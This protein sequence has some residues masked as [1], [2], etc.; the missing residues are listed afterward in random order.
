MGADAAK[1]LMIWREQASFR[2]A[3]EI[4]EELRKESDPAVSAA[5]TELR[6]VGRKEAEKVS[7]GEII[8]HFDPSVIT[9]GPG[10]P[11]DPVANQRLRVEFDDLFSHEYARTGDTGLAKTNA[12][13]L[14]EQVW[15]ATGVDG[16]S[17]IMRYPPE[18]Y[19]PRVDG[20]H[21]WLQKQA[22]ADLADI[23]PEGGG[24]ALHSDE[25]TE[26]AI[27]R[28]ERPHYALVVQDGNG[29]MNAL[30]WPRVQFDAKPYEAE[31]RQVFERQRVERELLELNLQA[32]AQPEATMGLG[33]PI[34]QPNDMEARKATLS[35]QLRGYA[36]PPKKPVEQ[37]ADP[38]RDFM[39]NV[40]GY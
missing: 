13:K 7:D 37:Q 16:S 9:P 26:A 4:V 6:K 12:L 17:R 5:R 29:V 34:K 40:T 39:G 33:A 38:S 20:S 36:P 8:N 14:L 35:D 10:A 19:Y 24:F 23:V 30:E 3:A 18:R 32:A 28:G 21:E 25:K 2:P 1:K 27:S 31:A 11:L 22:E 15:G